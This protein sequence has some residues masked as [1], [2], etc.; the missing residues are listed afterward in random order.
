MDIII[1]RQEKCFKKSFFKSALE[2][3]LNKL[4]PNKEI[5]IITDGDEA[6]IKA[7]RMLELDH[8]IVGKDEHPKGDAI[9]C[10][11]D[12]PKYI[13]MPP[14]IIDPESAKM[15][16]FLS[17]YQKNG[18]VGDGYTDIRH[19]FPSWKFRAIQTIFNMKNKG[20]HVDEE[21]AI[22]QFLK[23]K[24][25]AKVIEDELALGED[26]TIIHN[27]DTIDRT[28]MELDPTSP[29]FDEIKLRLTHDNGRAGDDIPVA[30]ETTT[31]L[32]DSETTRRAFLDELEQLRFYRNLWEQIAMNFDIYKTYA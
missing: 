22:S 25:S 7:C 9:I 11:W 19:Q 4:F 2:R 8:E 32:V 26:S 28:R 14:E 17:H 23:Y 30:D 5:K 27:V 21:Y 1:K 16:K 24:Q 6:V 13:N 15:A 29:I 12:G 20:I 10:F 18:S 3:A 31:M